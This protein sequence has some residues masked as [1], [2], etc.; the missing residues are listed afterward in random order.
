MSPKP[1]YCTCEFR[2]D[3]ESFFQEKQKKKTKKVE[4][5]DFEALPQAP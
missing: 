3:P 2:F 1:S 5:Q 4:A